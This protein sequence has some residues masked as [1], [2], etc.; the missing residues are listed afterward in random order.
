MLTREIIFFT[1]SGGIGKSIGVGQNRQ[2]Q[3]PSAPNVRR[4]KKTKKEE[5]RR[6]RER[7]RRRKRSEEEVMAEEES[8]ATFDWITSW[9]T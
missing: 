2:K 1:V 6:R 4:K 7:K 9:I 5:M 3:V 8:A